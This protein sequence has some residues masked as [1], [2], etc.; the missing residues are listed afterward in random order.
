MIRPSFD[1][2]VGYIP[3]ILQACSSH[4]SISSTVFDFMCKA[5][6]PPYP[7]G[8]GGR[9]Q[10]HSAGDVDTRPEAAPVGREVGRKRRPE[11]AALGRK[12]RP[13]DNSY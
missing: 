12:R 10:R 4:D 11:M 2:K 8:S 6:R 9:I 3:K 1:H 7:A 13:P 5:I